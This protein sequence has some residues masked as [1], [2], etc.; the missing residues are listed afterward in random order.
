[1]VGYMPLMDFAKTNRSPGE[2]VDDHWILKWFVL[3][4][5][6]MSAILLLLFLSFSTATTSETI[7]VVGLFIAFSLAIV[8]LGL[9]IEY[10]MY[11]LTGAELFHRREDYE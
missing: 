9:G 2:F 5:W 4:I 3:P 11:K 1:M 10:C 8:G 6:F 7:Q